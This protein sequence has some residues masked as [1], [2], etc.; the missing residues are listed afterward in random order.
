MAQHA[1]FFRQSG[2][3]MIS[4]ILTGVLMWAVHFLSKS[5][6]IPAQEYGLFV[7]LM[8]VAM[9]VPAMPLQMVLAQQTAIAL[10]TR[11]VR[12]LSA[13][14]RRV[15]AVTFVL[16]II[17]AVG[18]LLFRERILLQWST[19]NS[20]ALYIML[21]VLLFSV[22]GPM[23]SGLLQG[24]QNFL[25]LGWGSILQACVRLSVAVIA[26]LGFGANAAGI[27]TGV[28][29]GMA[30]GQVVLLW[31]SRSIWL[32]APGGNQQDSA[33]SSGASAAASSARE[34][35]SGSGSGGSSWDIV[36]APSL[37]LDWR[38]LLRQVLPLVLGFGAYQ[39]MFTADTMFAKAYFNAE[40]MGFYGS[41]GT[42]SRALMWLVGPLAAVMFPKIVHSSARSEKTNLMGIV[43]LGTAILAI[44]GAL[45][46]SIVGR[47]VVPV[48]FTKSYVPVATA[49][50]PWYAGA[51]VPL[52]LANVLINNLLAR[53]LYRAVPGLC[54]VA[55]AYGIALTRFHE[56]FIM[57]LQVFGV[58]NLLL[59]A[60]CGWYTMQD[61]RARRQRAG[62]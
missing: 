29:L 12:E 16:W 1:K 47:W 2:W 14:V 31:Q 32:S 25:W 38:G 36:G 43:L 28:V 27:M 46:L 54:L 13:M 4:G 3:L 37:A 56:S 35:T 52:S 53:G 58:F 39:F 62:R 45:G 5:K 19:S 7:A 42:L 51:M 6:A 57:V 30:A 10:A 55:V 48:V 22:W 8:A 20:T 59:L 34:T 15:C 9:C 17:A 44:M 24:Q 50:L 40:Q 26:V 23:F 41:A 61:K 49:V 60:V 11:R 33:G 21:P 18:I